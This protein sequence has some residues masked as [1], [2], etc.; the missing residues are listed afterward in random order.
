MCWAWLQALRMLVLGLLVAGTAVPLQ[1]AVGAA[2]ASMWP[3]VAEL[4][5]IFWVLS[6]MAASAALGYIIGDALP[7]LAEVWR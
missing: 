3:D 5:P 1:H 2:A 6:L 4:R 7:F